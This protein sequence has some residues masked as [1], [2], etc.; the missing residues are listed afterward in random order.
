MRKQLSLGVLAATFLASAIA[1]VGTS[2]ATAGARSADTSALPAASG[3]AASD[4]RN[5]NSL[6]ERTKKAA[7]FR[8][9]T[10]KELRRIVS[11]VQA[12][13]KEYVGR[14]FPAGCLEIAMVAKRDPNWVVTQPKMAMSGRCAGLAGEPNPIRLSKLVG[15]R[16]LFATLWTGVGQGTCA[17]DARDIF[18]GGA[19]PSVVS[20]WV[21]AEWFPGAFVC[22]GD[23]AAASMKNDTSPLR[24]MSSSTI[25]RVLSETA[26]PSPT[27]CESTA[28]G[29]VSSSDSNWGVIWWGPKPLG[30][31]VY[32]DGFIVKKTNG[33]WVAAEEVLDDNTYCDQLKSDMVSLGGANYPKRVY[34]DFVNASLC[35]S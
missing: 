23:Y 34:Q 16:L 10:P 31:G 9:A 30:C 35:A 15:S 8:D 7:G 17:R 32:L 20:A 13:Y 21:G 6:S 19:K 11:A 5:S 14:E 3:V 12:G 22:T 27:F 29:L 28:R 26:I 24:T 33:K 2:V 1:P 18:L 4:T 25:Q